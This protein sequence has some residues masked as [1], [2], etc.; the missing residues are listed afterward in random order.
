MKREFLETLDLGEGV[1][2]PKSAIDAI[3]AENGKDINEAK[4]PIAGLTTE[5]D[6]YKSQLDEANKKLVGYD[7]EWKTKAE[8][9]DKEAKAKIAEIQMDMLIK[10]ALGGYEF[11]SSFS[12]DGIAAK[13]KAAG[14]KA[15]EDG[16]SLLG[17]DDLMTKLKE[18][19][20]DAFKEPDGGGSG[21]GEDGKTP[22]G[23]AGSGAGS[24]T[25]PKNEPGNL[26]DAVSAAL[27]PTKN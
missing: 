14:L 7:P 12:A 15:A 23:A 8:Q 18:Q 21:A 26:R 17:L 5:R 3:M 27:F 19:H 2:L 24:G 22:F 4:A 25:P 16:K 11:T 9:A 10:D 6:T 1:K 13:V 20:P